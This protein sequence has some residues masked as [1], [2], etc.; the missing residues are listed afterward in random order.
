MAIRS[1]HGVWLPKE[2][3]VRA[4]KWKK[5]EHERWDG[6][7]EERYIREIIYGKRG[8]V[9]YWEIKTK[10]EKE[11][12]KEGGSPDQRVIIKTYVEKQAKNRRRI[13]SKLRNP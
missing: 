11:E 1:N 7:Q 13:F 12:E 3:R 6:K 9:R 10:E 8:E 4:N 5:F 2:A